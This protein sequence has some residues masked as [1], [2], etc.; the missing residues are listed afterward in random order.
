ESYY[1]DE[2]FHIGVVHF[3]YGAKPLILMDDLN[4]AL[5]VATHQK[6]SGWFLAEQDKPAISLSK[7][8]VRWRTLLEGVLENSGLL[9]YQQKIV[10]FEEKSELYSEIWPRIKDSDNSVIAA[11]T[12]LPM[13]E[14]CGLHEKFDKQMLE[15]TISLLVARGLHAKP[16]AINLSDRILMD[17]VIQKWF[18]YE[19]MQLPRATRENL[20]IEVSEELIAKNYFSL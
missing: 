14:K 6:V 2:F 11:G 8:T 7:G 1:A 20:V 16:I 5:L 12:F 19:L 10:L 13:A 3:H 9:L 4:H 15:K 18:V 17:K